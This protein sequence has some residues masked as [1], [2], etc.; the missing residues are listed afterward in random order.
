[1]LQPNGDANMA[2]V[3]RS[4]L[5]LE[6][7]LHYQAGAGIVLDSDP[8]RETQEVH[9]KLRAVREAIR[10]ANELQSSTEK[11]VAL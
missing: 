8:K 2:I 9:H 5:S 4:I 6:N 1:M 10:K 3:I 7:V 11:L